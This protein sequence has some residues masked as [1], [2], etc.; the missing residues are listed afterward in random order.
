MAQSESIKRISYVPG[1]QM[2]VPLPAASSKPEFNAA[3][4][5]AILRKSNS[6]QEISQTPEIDKKVKM[7]LSMKKKA[8]QSNTM[9]GGPSDIPYS[10]EK[11]NRKLPDANEQSSFYY[12]IKGGQLTDIQTVKH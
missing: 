3:A 1:K 4:L 2:K 10:T 6:Q 7:F 8:F 9:H 5:G 12:Q 11:Q